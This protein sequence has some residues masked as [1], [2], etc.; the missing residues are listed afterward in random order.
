MRKFD[1][2]SQKSMK[3]EFFIKIYVF[4]VF[5]TFIFHKN[6]LLLNNYDDADDKI[7]YLII[8]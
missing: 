2:F 6:N 3:S 1:I 4:L 7:T 5:I 8:I